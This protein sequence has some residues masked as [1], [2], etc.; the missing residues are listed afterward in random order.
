MYVPVKFAM[1]HAAA[2][3]VVDDAG[4]GM[5]VI[6][7]V[8]GMGSVFTPVV[9]DDDR[10]TMR[11]H[12]ARA[13][14]WW[15]HAQ[16]ADVLGLFVVASA[17]VTPTYYPSRFEA[18]GVVPTWNYVAAEVRGRITVRDDAQWL[19]SQVGLLT[20]HFEAGR[21]P[22]WKVSDSPDEYIAQQLKAIV[23]I[24][25]EVLSI[26]GKSKLSQNRPVEDHESVREHL[27]VGTLA[28]RNV[29]RRMRLD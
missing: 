2:W 24:E 4:A 6:N 14:P 18:P 7:A 25:I 26:E 23:G 13:N 5:L 22:E 11:A 15:R 19:A 9:V 16:G 12:V 28:E 20:E 3:A 27:A 21:D 17:Y 8:D 29:A 10:R 1:D